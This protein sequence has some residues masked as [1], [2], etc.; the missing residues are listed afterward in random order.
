MPFLGG[1]TCDNN[2]LIVHCYLSYLGDVDVSNEEVTR[3]H[4]N[5][6][7]RPLSSDLDLHQSGETE[8]GRRRRRILQVGDQVDS[9]GQ[10][11]HVVRKQVVLQRLSRL[12]AL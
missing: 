4:A 12:S 9:I 1:V 11:L 2:H 3:V 7:H 10:R 5:L 6:R 8:I